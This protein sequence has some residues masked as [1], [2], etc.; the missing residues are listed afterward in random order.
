MGRDGGIE[1]GKLV[2]TP[3]C[4]NP[5]E[6]S[7]LDPCVNHRRAPRALLPGIFT[8]VCVRTEVMLLEETSFACP[9][10]D[11]AALIGF[12][13]SEKLNSGAAKKPSNILRST[14]T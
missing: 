5:L 1:I 4:S 7:P 6:T 14:P 10:S 12:G 8:I 11:F 9:A 13:A 2:H 3:D